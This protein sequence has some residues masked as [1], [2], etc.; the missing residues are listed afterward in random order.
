MRK[1]NRYEKA[2]LN[3]ERIWAKVSR[4]KHIPP[5][6][7]RHLQIAKARAYWYRATDTERLEK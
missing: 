3:A 2:N 7:E 4:R 6:K 5:K 1:I